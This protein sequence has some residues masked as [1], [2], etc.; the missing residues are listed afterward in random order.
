MTAQ[1]EDGSDT[2]L[3]YQ[4]QSTPEA[5]RDTLIAI[6][7][8]LVECNAAEMAG[9]LWELVVAEVLNNIV[10]HAYSEKPNGA[11]ELEL[12]F[13]SSR[14]I[15]SFIDYGAPM[16]DGAL[17]ANTPANVDVPIQNLPEGGFGWHFIH[18]LSDHLN[19]ERSN[20]RNCLMLEMSLADTP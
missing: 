12:T 15:A 2:T 5:V 18:T 19:Y 17:P 7:G 6:K 14:M 4:L 20:S 11:I 8:A 10:E 13:A 16:P 3:R 1:A 9:D